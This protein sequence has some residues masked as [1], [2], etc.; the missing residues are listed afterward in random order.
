MPV[1]ESRDRMPVPGDRYVITVA[2]GR[3]FIERV[4]PWPCGKATRPAAGSPLVGPGPFADTYLVWGRAASP[5]RTTWDEIYD[6]AAPSRA[7]LREVT[8]RFDTGGAKP[9]L[10]P[11]SVTA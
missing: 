6:S 11:C 8:Y 5:V 10:R 2:G 1:F 7:T 3:W 9:A 4:A